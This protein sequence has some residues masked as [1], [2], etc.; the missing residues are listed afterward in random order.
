[1]ARIGLTPLEKTL[2]SGPNF[3]LADESKRQLSSALL[4]FTARVRWSRPGIVGVKGRWCSRTK[5]R[6]RIGPR[7][8]Q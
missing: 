8:A 3:R 4:R 2:F 6:L 7:V 5:S 1:M